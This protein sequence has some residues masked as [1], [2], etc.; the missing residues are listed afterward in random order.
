[1]VIDHALPCRQE[2]INTVKLVLKFLQIEVGVQQFFSFSSL[3]YQ[4]IL[5]PRWHPN[6]VTQK[7]VSM[8]GYFDL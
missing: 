4:Y 3:P 5:D 1:M 6:T 7:T 8:F 2:T